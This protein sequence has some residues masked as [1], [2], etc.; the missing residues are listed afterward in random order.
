MSIQCQITATNSSHLSPQ[1]TGLGNVL[2]QISSAYGFSKLYDLKHNAQQLSVYLEKLKTTL[3]Y[4]YKDTI[5]RNFDLTCKFMPTTIIN[6]QHHCFALYD[7]NLPIQISSRLTSHIQLNGYF[8]SHLYFDKYRDDI[9]N[10][11]SIDSDSL[12]IIKTKYP[13]LF[14]ETHTCV[15][16][17]FRL[18]WGHGIHYCIDYYK[19]AIQKIKEQIDAPYFLIFSDDIKII[20]SILPSLD[21][22]YI[23]VDGNYDYIDLWAMSLCKH[24][25]LSFSTFSWWGA[26][27]NCNPDKKVFYP[28]DGLR[29]NYGLHPSPVLIDR[30]SQHYF[31]DW[32]PLSDKSI[33]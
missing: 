22:E 29:V 2:F 18:N 9:L 16:M 8:Q 12:G 7:S 28:Y 27:L 30:K 15:S 33:L 1:N 21:I 23:I 14:D 20:R 19:Q 25:I 3:G 31:S 4:D 26:Y 5:F 24:N 10:L 6:E 17:H 11:F 13:I 32:I